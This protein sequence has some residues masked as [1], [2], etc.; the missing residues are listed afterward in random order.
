MI[1]VENHPLQ[2]V[3]QA[4]KRCAERFTVFWQSH[5]GGASNSDGDRRSAQLLHGSLQ[6]RLKVFSR[7]KVL[8]T[9]ALLAQPLLA[10]PQN[11]G[12]AL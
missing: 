6:T 9:P 2:A 1:A 3:K 10:G 11:S 4:L 8:L 7:G 12:R 5:N